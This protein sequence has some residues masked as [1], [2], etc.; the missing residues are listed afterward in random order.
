[1]WVKSCI[2]IEMSV[3]LSLEQAIKSQERRLFKKG[4][5]NSIQQRLN[6]SVLPSVGDS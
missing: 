5:N 2:E 1:M 3:S 4:K 6:M